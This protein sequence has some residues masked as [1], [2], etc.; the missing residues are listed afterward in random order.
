MPFDVVEEPNRDGLPTFYEL[1]AWAWK[2]NLSGPHEDW[3]PA[4]SGSFT[5]RHTETDECCGSRDVMTTRRS[6]PCPMQIESIADIVRVHGAARP[7][8]GP[9]ARRPRSRGPSCTS[10]PRRVATG[11]GVAASAPEDRVAL[12]DK[13]GIEHFEVFFGAA[14]LNAVCVD[15]NWRLA[16]P[17]SPSSSTTRRPRC[18]SSA[19]TSCRCSTASGPT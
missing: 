10:G 13:N 12:L 17:R 4:G 19:P 9:V 15:V 8:G 3:N 6:V 5:E 7:D 16:P 2:E 14:L 1:H 11:L 18:S